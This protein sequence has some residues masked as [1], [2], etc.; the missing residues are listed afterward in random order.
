MLDENPIHV[1][2][3]L[4]GDPNTS[5]AVDY[6]YPEAFN[7]TNA[8]EAASASASLA[9]QSSAYPTPTATPTPM[10]AR[11]LSTPGVRNLT[12]PPYAINN[13]LPGHSLVKQVLSPDAVHRN[14]MTEYELHNLYGHT[15]ANASYHALLEA[16]PGKRPW[17][18]ARATF[19]GTGN[20]SGHWGGDTN[21][22]WGNMYFGISQALQF[23]IAGIPVRV[24]TFW[25]LMAAYADSFEVFWCR[26][27]RLQW[28]RRHAAL[29][30][31]GAAVCLVPALP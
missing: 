13:F 15:S 27:L 28:Q 8:T 6:R 18:Q 14:G 24:Y 1:P 12:F 26:D 23:A 3:P 21:S 10:L 16:I 2:F 25:M 20:F 4:P 11:T 17:I 31:L 5:V 7:L 19:A 29:H 9:S 30:P 22:K